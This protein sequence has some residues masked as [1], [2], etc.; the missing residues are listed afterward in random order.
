MDHVLP[1][2]DFELIFPDRETSSEPPV[3]TRKSPVLV[4]A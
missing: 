2:K 4:W 3:P 1:S